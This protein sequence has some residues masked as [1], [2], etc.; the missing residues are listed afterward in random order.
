MKLFIC[1]QN[2]LFLFIILWN[3]ER[4]VAQLLSN[5][6]ITSNIYLNYSI[7]AKITITS[8]LSIK[9]STLVSRLEELELARNTLTSPICS[10]VHRQ[11]SPTRFPSVATR[12]PVIGKLPRARQ[13][14]GPVSST[15]QPAS[16][17]SIESSSTD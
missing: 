16:F 12:R 3:D 9:F 8:K 6:T 15:R 17:S 7:N 2:Y 4:N 5:H 13:D 1:C 14:R 10:L 11:Y